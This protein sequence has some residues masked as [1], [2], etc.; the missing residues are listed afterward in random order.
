MEFNTINITR[1]EG[2]PGLKLE[3]LYQSYFDIQ[4]ALAA[5]R[6]P[7]A[8][9]VETLVTNAVELAKQETLSDQQ[10][11]LL[12]DIETNASHLHHVSISEA[13]VKFKPISHAV[14]TLCT[15]LRGVQA[16]R[17]FHQ[18]FCPMVKDGEGDWLQ[19]DSKLIN[20]YYGSQM[21]TCGEL[22]RTIPPDANTDSQTKHDHD[23]D[24]GEK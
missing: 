11:E 7:N 20:P 17:P 15:Q 18:F 10:K 21:L 16:K 2:D 24:K 23:K 8:T 1:L 5:D 3:N 13:R 22:V 12:T 19:A 6:K 14:V 9:E 4:K